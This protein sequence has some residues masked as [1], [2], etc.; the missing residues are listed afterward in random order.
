MNN[1]AKFRVLGV[2]AAS[3]G[4]D[5]AILELGKA[6]KTVEPVATP[7]VLDAAARPTIDQE[8][9]PWS[10]PPYT[11]SQG[12]RV[13]PKVT[14][15][16]LG[17]EVRFGIRGTPTNKVG[18]D[19]D[20][21]W[22]WLNQLSHLKFNGGPLFNKEGQVVAMLSASRSTDRTL[23]SAIHIKHVID[24]LPKDDPKP[25]SLKSLK[26]IGDARLVAGLT[27]V[28]E[29]PSDTLSGLLQRG[30]P[31]DQRFLD[32]QRRIVQ[33]EMEK[34]DMEKSDIRLHSDKIE[35]VAEADKI[36]IAFSAMQPEERFTTT[37]TRTERGTRTVTRRE[38][39]SDGEMKNVQREEPFTKVIEVTVEHFRFSS[40]QEQQR[41]FSQETMAKLNAKIQD[42]NIVVTS[43]TNILVPFFLQ[44]RRHLEDEIFFFADPMG[45]RPAAEHELL[46]TELSKVIEDGGAS[47][48]IF[49]ARALL[50]CNEA[51]L[52]GAE[53]DLIE[54][55]EL[56]T[57]Y[58]LLVRTLGARIKLLRGDKVK[59]ASELKSVLNEKN[60][61]PKI[62]LVASRIEIDNGNFSF[63][64]KY[65]Q[66]AAKLDQNEAEI[67]LGIAWVA[68][69]LPNPSAKIATE[70]AEEAVR[71]TAGNDWAALSVLAA[72]HALSKKNELAREVMD[73]AILVAPATASSVC[74]RWKSR[75]ESDHCIEMDWK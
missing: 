73:A 26:G 13:F 54:V 45:L 15:S 34:V 49:M 11:D 67:S 28:D 47:A 46:Q 41:Q 8:L 36:Q 44:T 57:R 29:A 25:R 33:V 16:L 1:G 64:L 10:G 66:D 19:P 40:R 3:K 43:D 14:R 4:K 12:P 30:K 22:I 70:A 50:R 56:D 31:V 61:D 75:L 71:K 62:L 53:S 37:E 38:R 5:I 59:A 58:R 23:F 9:I 63:A 72:A 74:D 20:V 17:D 6:S 60:L 7:L 55:S 68:A 18:D 27:T 21:R 32:W 2:V 51:D 65:L 69:S 48:A 52:D 42:I 39:G 24:L 35:L